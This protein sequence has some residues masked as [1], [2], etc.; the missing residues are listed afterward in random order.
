SDFVPSDYVDRICRR[1]DYL[2]RAIEMAAVRLRSMSIETLAARLD[3]RFRLLTGGSRT[4]PPR[5]RTLRAVVEWSWDLL[6]DTERAAADRAAA[7]PGSFCA[8]AAEHVGLTADILHALVDKSLLE[9]VAGRYRMLDTVRE[10]GIEQLAATGRLAAARSAHAH[11]FLELAERAEPHLRGSGQL[12]WLT[13]LDVERH[14]MNAAIAFAVDSEDTDT[15]VR[16]GA[17]LG[18]FW[19]VHGDHAEAIRKLG[20]IVSMP[21]PAATE[22]RLRAIAA[23]LVN[24]IF[25][26]T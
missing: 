6:T 26:G 7:F 12:P 3:D 8:E 18:Q 11:Y 2:P 23:Y 15:A 1:L 17:A 20:D 24:A 19:T 21:G 4:A 5:H 25:A 14:N 10:F 13:R 22:A 9:Y 16:L